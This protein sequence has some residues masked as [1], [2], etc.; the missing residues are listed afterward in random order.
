MSILPLSG[1]RPSTDSGTPPQFSLRC[2]RM[3]LTMVLALAPSVLASHPLN[4]SFGNSEIR[5]ERWFPRYQQKYQQDGHPTR[6]R[7]GEKKRWRRDE[8]VR[9][10]LGKGDKNKRAARVLEWGVT[11]DRLPDRGGF[12]AT[13][14]PDQE[15]LGDRPGPGR[16][17][18]PDLPPGARGQRKLGADGR[19]LK[20]LLRYRCARISPYFTTVSNLGRPPVY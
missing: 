13:R 11:A 5:R 16:G 10:Q 7:R 14:T 6:P 2:F 9:C 18:A 8:V 12:R 1:S 3:R 4:S 15:D 17:R 19:Q 20:F